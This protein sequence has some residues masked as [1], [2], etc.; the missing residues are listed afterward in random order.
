MLSHNSRRGPASN[1]II[2]CILQMWKHFLCFI[3]QSNFW[4]NG[5]WKYLYLVW[6]QETFLN[7][8]SPSMLEAHIN[9]IFIWPRFRNI[10]F[11]KAEF[12]EIYSIICSHQTLEGVKHKK[13]S[14]IKGGVINI[15]G[16]NM[17]VYNFFLKCCLK[18]FKVW[19][20]E[21]CS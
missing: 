17:C 6:N 11:F 12:L 16:S 7:V 15:Y 3:L 14:T 5:W 13:P 8:N 9:Y 4:I 10:P 19:N 2:Y 20:F 18:L 1:L 21:S